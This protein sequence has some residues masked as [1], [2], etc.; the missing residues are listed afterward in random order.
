MKPGTLL[1]GD[2]VWVRRPLDYSLKA[3]C[4]RRRPIRGVYNRVLGMVLGS[5]GRSG[6]EAVEM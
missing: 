5:W 4:A 2:L 6:G 3:S 1:L